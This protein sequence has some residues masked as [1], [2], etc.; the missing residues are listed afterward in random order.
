MKRG[1]KSQAERRAIALR[2]T[3]GLRAIDPLPARRLAGH[4]GY[5]VTR[6]AGVGGLPHTVTDWMSSDRCGWSALMITGDGVRLIIY[7]PAHGEGR[8]E[9]SLMHELAHHLCGHPSK[10]IDLGGGLALRHFVQEHEEEAA[11]LG[12]CLQLP[13]RALAYHARRSSP[14]QVALLFTASHDML[15]YRYGV[16]GLRRQFGFPGW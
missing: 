8:Q 6:P 2:E 14:D 10:A 12:A 9:S 3:L 7:N 5:Q 4:L 13:R 16:T 11:W 1:F 15:R